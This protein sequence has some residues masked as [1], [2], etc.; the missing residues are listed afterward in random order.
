VV[1]AGA[2]ALA[3]A[4]TMLPA[5]AQ[6]LPGNCKTSATVVKGGGDFDVEYSIKCG[7]LVNTVKLK[8]SKS[9][10]SVQSSPTLTAPEGDDDNA[11]TCKKTK[12]RRGRCDGHV[13]EDTAIKGSLRLKRPCGK[14]RATLDLK[15]LGGEDSHHGPSLLRP[16]SAER[17]I[18]VRGCGKSA[19]R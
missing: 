12:P 19:A 18:T 4:V 15:I 5:S 3:A 8:A 6:A 1:V 11:L 2:V 17:S 13:H 7:F 16:M 10:M 14:N 9:M